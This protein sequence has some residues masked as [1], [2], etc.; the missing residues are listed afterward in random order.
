[1]TDNGEQR[2]GGESRVRRENGEEA[3]RAGGLPLPNDA[4]G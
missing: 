4:Q 1:M 2:G 3:K